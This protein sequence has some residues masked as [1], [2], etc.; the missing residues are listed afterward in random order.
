MDN[1]IKARITETNDGAFYEAL[2][3]AIPKVGEYITLYSHL[4]KSTGYNP[5]H[6]Y[7]VVKV[8]HE[9]QDVTEKVEK[10][11]VGYHAVEI[12]VKQSNAI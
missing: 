6:K 3:E 7:E 5:Q 11:K 12:V 1:K 10:S 4:D 8:I 9:I 2:L